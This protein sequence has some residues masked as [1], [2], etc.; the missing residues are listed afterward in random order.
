M[1]KWKWSWLQGGLL[2]HHVML[3]ISVI[4]NEMKSNSFTQFISSISSCDMQVPLIHILLLFT[5][6]VYIML[7]YLESP[8]KL[9]YDVQSALSIF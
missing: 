6:E 1:W 2:C 3:T 7:P 8:L 9:T 4:L 5:N